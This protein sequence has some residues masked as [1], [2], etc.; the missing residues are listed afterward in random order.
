MELR[1]I[2]NFAIW[3]DTRDITDTVELPTTHYDRPT[4][5]K[6]WD[7]LDL[8]SR[9]FARVIRELEG[10]LARTV[11]LFLISSLWQS[12]G[13]ILANDLQ[14]CLFYLVLRAL[15]TVEDDMTIPNDVK[16]PLLRAMHTK[17]YEPGWTFK[18]SKEKDKI[19]LEEFDAIQTEFSLLDHKYVH[20]T[21]RLLGRGADRIG[22]G[23]RLSLP[24][25]ARR[26]VLVWPTLP[27]LLPPG[28]L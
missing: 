1:A 8:T 12:T 25:F 16:I 27:P 7:F 22:S 20:N 6:C 21:C 28:N 24:I 18:E 10:E 14:V 11:R 13:T 3:H 17:L 15:D 9:S 19:V 4:M 26:W 23:T 2:V 5:R